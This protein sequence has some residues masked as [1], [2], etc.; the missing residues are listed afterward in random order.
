MF[1]IDEFKR[2]FSVFAEERLEKELASN[3]LQLNNLFK[4]SENRYVSYV[5]DY[6]WFEA[7]KIYAEDHFKIRISDNPSIAKGK[8]TSR[9]KN[10]KSKTQVNTLKTMKTL[11]NIDDP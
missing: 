10:F 8:A 5:L 9:K 6:K 3:F 11:N 1:N 4:E 2:V 7:W